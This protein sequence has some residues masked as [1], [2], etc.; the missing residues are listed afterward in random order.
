V[1]GLSS[2]EARKRLQEYG[3]N[4]LPEKRLKAL[5]GPVAWVLRDGEFKRLPAREIVPGDVVRLEAGDR[6]PADGRL[7][8][9]HGALADES[10]SP[11]RA[12]PWKRAPGRRSTPGPSWSGAG[13]FWRW[14][15][16]G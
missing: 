9:A 7:L 1:R 13:P 8:E 2:E 10:V 14:P 6:V 5:A 3:P 12:F 16:P 4:A 11:G 15:A